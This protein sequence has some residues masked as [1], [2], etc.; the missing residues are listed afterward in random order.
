MDEL[1]QLR[2]NKFKKLICDVYYTCIGYY[3]S[4]KYQVGYPA[5]LFNYDH[6]S[7]HG[8]EFCFDNNQIE[9]FYQGFD[10]SV[11][12]FDYYTRL[13]T[14]EYMHYLQ[15]PGWFKRYYKM[16]YDYSNHPYELEAYARETELIERNLIQPTI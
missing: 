2:K 12:C 1:D 5:L 8:G 15:C 16:G 9:V 13:V 10:D 4:S 7:I 11:E 14:H 3:G 6:D